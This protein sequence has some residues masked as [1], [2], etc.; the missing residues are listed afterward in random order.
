MAKILREYQFGMTMSEEEMKVLDLLS[1][2]AGM[3]RSGFVRYVL[4]QLKMYGVATANIRKENNN[5]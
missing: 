1:E 3:T 2:K 4:N 5:G